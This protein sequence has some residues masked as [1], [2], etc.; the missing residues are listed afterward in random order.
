[1]NSCSFNHSNHPASMSLSLY[2]VYQDWTQGLLALADEDEKDSSKTT[3]TLVH[4]L[5]ERISVFNGK[6]DRITDLFV[7]QDIDRET[8]LAKKRGLM[9]EKRSVEEVLA[10]SQRGGS[11]WLEPMRE[12]IKDA[13]TLDEIAKGDDL[14]SKKSSLQKIFGSDLILRNKKVEESPVKQ[15]ATLCVARKNFS[16]NDLS[17]LLAGGQGLEPTTKRLTVTCS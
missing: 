5:R 2:S 9:S 1:M 15:W 13:S 8:Y 11:P 7:E 4:G 12:R 10:K 6:I 3:V 16:N 14:P 17:F